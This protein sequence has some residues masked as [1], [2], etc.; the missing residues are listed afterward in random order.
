MGPI[1]TLKYDLKEC[2]EAGTIPAIEGDVGVGKTAMIKQIAREVG[3]ELH[4]LLGS[5]IDP[6]LDLSGA[7][8]VLPVRVQGRDGKEYPVTEFAV[9]EWVRRLDNAPLA[10]IC[11]DELTGTPPAVMAAELTMLTDGRVGNFYFD[12]RRV[13]F[14]AM[15][16]PPDIAANGQELPPPMLN[17]LTHFTFPMSVDVVGEWCS[18]FINYWDYPPTIGRPGREIPESTMIRARSAFAGFIKAN[19]R[20]WHVNLDQG[21]GTDKE[22]KSRTS[23][24]KAQEQTAKAY[25]TPRS[26]DRASRHLGRCLYRGADPVE[27]LRLIE[28]EIGVGAAAEFIA[29]Y[30]SADLPDPEKLLLAP[31]AYTPTGRP[32]LDFTTMT[33]VAAAFATDPTPQR[34]LAAWKVLGRAVTV[35][36]VGGSIAYEAGSAA[37]LD[38]AKW[39]TSEK[40]LVLYKGMQKKDIGK[41]TVELVAC[42][43]PYRALITKLGVQL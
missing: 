21:S 29:Y 40:Q 38:L 41:L 28:A 19:P 24:E 3:A 15:Y 26:I 12:M 4:I 36:G 42:A 35:R 23:K 13:W 11:L 9:P 33:A 16:N 22:T 18:S 27:C 34:Y 1:E 5:I 17:R 14:V 2:F 43:S 7:P 20:Q 6:V 25:P 32:D 39:L 10:I 37:A 8:V 30:R 31:D